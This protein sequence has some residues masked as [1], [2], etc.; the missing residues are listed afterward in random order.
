MIILLNP[1][2]D[3]SFKD[4]VNTAL[5]IFSAIV[6]FL[7]LLI[8]LKALQVILI[9]KASFS[10]F[11]VWV[12]LAIGAGLGLFKSYTTFEFE[13][14]LQLHKGFEITMQ[15]RI[16][17]GIG[18]WMLIVPGFAMISN[19]MEQAKAR[20][21]VVMER[22]VIAEALKSSNEVILE[23]TKLAARASIEDE[24]TQLLLVASQEIEASKGK[25]LEKQYRI[26]AAVLT[27]AAENL[28]RPLSHELM[29]EHRLEFPAP[30]TWQ[31]F[32]SSVRRP[33]LPILPILVATNISVATLAIRE[34]V[35]LHILLIMCLLQSVVVWLA[36]LLIL[37]IVSHFI[38]FGQLAFFVGTLFTVTADRL[39][40]EL[41]GIKG[42]SFSEDQRLLL[43]F[44]WFF[45]LYLVISFVAQLYK[46][47][48]EVEFFVE[49]MINSK[50]IDQKLIT[51]ETLRVK[52]D[53][54]R[55]L[56][57][58]LQSRIMSLGL[59]LELNKNQDQ[60]SLD[61]ALSLAQSLLQSPFTE[62]LEQHE[63]TLIEEVEFNCGKWS[64]LLH[65]QTDIEDIDSHLSFAQKRA[66]GAALEEALANALRH[67]FANSIEI[68]VFKEDAGVTVQVIDDGIGP[69]E[70][71]AGLGSKLYDSVASRGWTLQHRRDGNG[72]ILELQL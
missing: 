18:A 56:H 51:D 59:T 39:G 71:G 55:Y 49:K 21:L 13:R 64:G 46:S 33:S 11:P 10:P 2:V 41:L 61:S 62:Y 50:I 45:S 7:L 28:I 47:E 20:R 38:R 68:R 53:I 37:K 4:P 15:S 30:R 44:L 60:A 36:V 5:W 25:T 67:G 43:N 22:L 42:Y 63:R 17:G 31:I 9:K 6:P 70:G 58:N 16:F 8:L 23:Q 48:N 34:F 65:I 57:G 19:Y 14:I 35:P 32:L 1:I 24:V 72:T 54:A 40:L 29:A 3:G 66:V 27:H 12:I 26:I 52:H 69:R